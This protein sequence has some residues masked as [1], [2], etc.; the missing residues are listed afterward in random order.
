MVK[1]KIKPVTKGT[2]SLLK[3]IRRLIEETRSAVASTVNAG[4]TM[5]YWQIGKR[6][7]EEILKGKR[8]GYGEEILQTL[9]AK[10]IGEFGRGF[11]QRNLS[12]MV[13]FFESFPD[14]WIVS[15]L[16]RQLGW[17]HFV[18]HARQQLE[19][20]IPERTGKKKKS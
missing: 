20:R 19:H 6:I 10:L 9:S 8:A 12:S 11:S 4:L 15:T 2:Q 16:W 17:S 5:L 3:D 18:V 14:Q 7:N 13:R 1:K